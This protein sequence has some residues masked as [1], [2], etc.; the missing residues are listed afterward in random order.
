MGDEEAD[1]TDGAAD[2]NSQAG[3]ERSGDVNDEAN[4]ADVNAEVHGFFFAGKEKIEIGRGGVN[5]SRGEKE[6][7]CGE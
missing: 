6:T 4:A 7:R 2:G 3:E 5:D 1:V